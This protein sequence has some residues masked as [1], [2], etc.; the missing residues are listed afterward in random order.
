MGGRKQLVGSDAKA[1]G[2]EIESWEEEPLD[3]VQGGARREC[4]GGAC[5]EG[6]E[7]G[8]KGGQRGCPKTPVGVVSNPLIV[9]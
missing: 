2:N 7:G 3:G 9:G 4:P 5:R 8:G 1:D 6:L